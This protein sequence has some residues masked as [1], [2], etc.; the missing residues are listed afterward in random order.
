MIVVFIINL[1][2]S[3]MYAAN[4]SKNWTEPVFA[5]LI[6]VGGVI[7]WF[8]VYRFSYVGFRDE[9]N[10]LVFLFVCLL[11]GLLIGAAIL[12]LGLGHSGGAGLVKLWDATK[13]RIWTTAF[14]LLI[15][16]IAWWIGILFGLYVLFRV[17][18][19]NQ[20]MGKP[21]VDETATPAGS[22]IYPPAYTSSSAA[23]IAVGPAPAPL[24]VRQYTSGVPNS[25]APQKVQADPI[26]SIA[27]EHR[28]QI[29]QAIFDNRETV[30]KAAQVAYDNRSTVAAVAKAAYET[31]GK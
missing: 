22:Q 18:N 15:A 17:W 1:V 26:A 3:V 13:S 8:A 11:S 21:L 30:V 20:Q 27:W 12:S 19:A 28:D 7:A 14:A 10:S 5:L 2:A 25:G 31:S 24:P 29:G 16:M 23:A 6:L 9:K 4:I